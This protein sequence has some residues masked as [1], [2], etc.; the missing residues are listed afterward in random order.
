[1]QQITFEIETVTPMFLSGADQNR[2]ELRAASIKGLLRYWWRAL[3]AESDLDKLRDRESRIFGSA[4]ERKGGASSFSIRIT[5]SAD[6]RTA[7][8]DEFLQRPHYKIPVEGKPFKMNILGYLAYGL[9]DIKKGFLR[10]YILPGEKFSIVI[11]LL[12]RNCFDDVIAAMLAFSLFGG[13]G[14]R[15][16]NGLGSFDISNR[17]EAFA[18][19]KDSFDI[20]NPYQTENLKKLAKQAGE[21]S[22]YSSFSKGTKVFRAKNCFSTGLDALADVGKTYRSGRGFLEAHYQ[23][24]KRQ[25]IGAPLDPPKQIF[26]SFLDRH[27]KPYFIKIAKEGDKYR[28]YILYLPSKY[29]DGLEKDRNKHPINHDKEDKKFAEVCADFNS[30]LLQSMDTII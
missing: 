10:D 17:T 14:S 24:Q 2:A 28:S 22:S 3:Q 9:Y 30:F 19:I 29:C 23:F 1:M 26:K 13:I 15:T 20:N 6:I 25:F 27:A 21:V 5:R 16:R 8:T 7:R 11:T 18:A 4:D 12:R